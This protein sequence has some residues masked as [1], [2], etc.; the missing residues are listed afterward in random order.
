[1][2]RLTKELVDSEPT[3][4]WVLSL[5]SDRGL[6][7]RLVHWGRQHAHG[8]WSSNKPVVLGTESAGV[9]VAVGSD[10]QHIKKGDRV[11]GMVYGASSESQGAASEGNPHLA[12]SVPATILTLIH[13]PL[14]GLVF[15][16]AHLWVLP[17]KM[18]DLEAAAFTVS[19]FNILC[20]STVQNISLWNHNIVR[21]FRPG[22]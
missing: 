10:V 6:N 14:I 16:A 18:S 12:A 20:L 1:M 19:S 15:D 8:E 17:P 2:A 4:R 21:G 3:I 7:S 22:I 11:A 5:C 13:C 9:A